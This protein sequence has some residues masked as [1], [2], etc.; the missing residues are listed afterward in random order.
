MKRAP[1]TIE[2]IQKRIANNKRAETLR[3]VNKGKI[4]SSK[5]K[6]EYIALIKQGWP[7]RKLEEYAMEHFNEKIS[8]VTFN[9]YRKDKI[10]QADLDPLAMFRMLSEASMIETIDQAKEI[11]LMINY[12]QSRIG[13]F[14]SLSPAFTLNYNEPNFIRL[15]LEAIKMYTE[16]TGKMPA[17]NVKFTFDDISTLINALPTDERKKYNSVLVDLNSDVAKHIGSGAEK[18]TE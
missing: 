3:E 13:S 11:L 16:I 1:I 15:Y 6:D 8:S 4:D 5:H 14:A 2:G 7:V 17:T 10:P 18:S 12:L 9:T